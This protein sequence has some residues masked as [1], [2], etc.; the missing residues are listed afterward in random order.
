M[1]MSRLRS[2]SLQLLRK[3]GLQNF[4]AALE[5]FTDLLN[6]FS[7]AIAMNDLSIRPKI[8]SI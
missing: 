7:T 6:S 4:Q 2:F 3:A 8:I 5:K 1:F